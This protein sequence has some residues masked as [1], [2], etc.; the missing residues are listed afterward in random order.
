MRSLFNP[1]RSKTLPPADL[2]AHGAPSRTTTILATAL[3][4]RMAKVSIETTGLVT[5]DINDSL[6]TIQLVDVTRHGGIRGWR[7]G[8]IKQGR[9]LIPRVPLIFGS[10]RQHFNALRIN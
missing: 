7:V 8:L 4:I 6:H 9:H 5:L 2:F 3:L 10:N 1:L